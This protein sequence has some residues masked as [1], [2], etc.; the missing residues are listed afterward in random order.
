MTE[1]MAKLV[2]AFGLTILFALGLGTALLQK[3][4]AAETVAPIAPAESLHT[5]QP[6]AA[7]TPAATPTPAAPVPIA[8]TQPDQF[9]ADIAVIVNYDNL[10]GNV[11]E[12][13]LSPTIR[14]IAIEVMRATPHDTFRAAVMKAK[15]HPNTIGYCA[16][17]SLFVRNFTR[18]FFQ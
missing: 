6:T 4:S 13:K 18:N 10:C 5:T 12:W 3:Q 1:N 16:D 7:T 14:K 2:S 8:T 9:L 11:P 15:P 17:T